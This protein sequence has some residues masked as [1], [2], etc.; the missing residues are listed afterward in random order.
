MTSLNTVLDL[1]MGYHPVH[2]SV[3]V[4]EAHQHFTET[5]CKGLCWNE[6]ICVEKLTLKP[7]I[8]WRKHKQ[9]KNN[10]LQPITTKS[11]IKA[12]KCG[13]TQVSVLG[14]KLLTLYSN[15]TFTVS[16]ILKFMMLFKFFSGENKQTNSRKKN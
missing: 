1:H 8:S 15:Y 10:M 12:V 7:S 5:V 9:K 3:P 16:S 14:P 2:L 4:K 11:Q 13:I 6:H